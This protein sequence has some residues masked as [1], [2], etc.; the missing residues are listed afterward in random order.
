[1][2][3]IVSDCEEL[4]VAEIDEK[5]DDAVGRHERSEAEICFLLLEMHNRRGF[6][7]F[8]FGTL[9]DYARERFGFTPRKTYY[10]LSLARKLEKLPQITK[11]F[12]EGRLRWFKAHKIASI[13]KPENEVMWL[14]SALSLAVQDLDRK[15][16]SEAGLTYTKLRFCLSEDQAAVVEYALEVCRKVSGAELTPE[17]CLEYMAA[18]FLAT[19]A[20]AAHREDNEAEGKDEGAAEE[21]SETNPSE[22]VAVEGDHSACP[23]N[24]D[25]PSAFHV[26]PSRTMISVFERDGWACTFP[27][28]PPAP[29]FTITTSSSGAALVR[30]RVKSVTFRRIGPPSVH[31]ITCSS[32]RESSASRD[33]RLSSSS[34]G[35][36]HSSTQ[37]RCG[38]RGKPDRLPSGWHVRASEIR[39]KKENCSHF[40]NCSRFKMWMA[41]APRP[42]PVESRPHWPLSRH[43]EEQ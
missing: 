17:Q 31:S 38:G 16:R 10:L 1:M 42:S 18:E 6:Q 32:M 7:K 24:G 11:A 4:T 33:G 23:E 12:E 5:L 27:G 20:Q 43:Q 2:S 8:G 29:C 28:V 30:R 3:L 36:P 25:M 37:R 15:I 21:A 13:A 40:K 19:Y 14:E 26:P 34:G 9:Q 39:A 22:A 35:S 41:G